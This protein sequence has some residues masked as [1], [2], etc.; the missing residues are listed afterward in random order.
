MRFNSL[1]LYFEKWVSIFRENKNGSFF[2]TNGQSFPIKSLR[3]QNHWYVID[4]LGYG[5]N[6]LWLCN[7]FESI[8]DLRNQECRKRKL[9]LK[10]NELCTMPFEILIWKI[11]GKSNSLELCYLGFKIILPIDK[12]DLSLYH[13]EYHYV[14]SHSLIQ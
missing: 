8:K 7:E 1:H 3:V 5:Q 11:N 14:A 10:C 13:F 2:L 9:I 4:Q 12:L 6:W